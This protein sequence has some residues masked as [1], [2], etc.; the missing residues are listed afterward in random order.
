MKSIDKLLR[1]LILASIILLRMPAEPTKSSA[2][3]KM[4][5]KD[6]FFISRL[7]TF[8][9]TFT[10]LHNGDNKCYTWHEANRGRNA[11]DIASTFHHVIITLILIFSPEKNANHQRLS[12]HQQSPH[13][14]DMELC[15]CIAPMYPMKMRFASDFKQQ[16]E[17]NRS[18]ASLPKLVSVNQVSSNISNASPIRASIQLQR[19][20]VYLTFP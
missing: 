20:V 11:P 4:I 1:N 13:Q 15:N 3:P 8:S 18:Y 7:V 6:S 2:S 9:E 5:T 10:P 12:S 16:T 14:E 17:L 19:D